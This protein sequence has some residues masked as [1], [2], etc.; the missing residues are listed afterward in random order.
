MWYRIYFLIIYVFS[1]NVSSNAQSK[2]PY[3]EIPSYP[4]NYTQGK[5]ISRMIDGLGYRFYWATENLRVL[6]L[7]F[8]PDTLARSTFETMEHIYGLSFMI[9]N[10]SK[11][12]VNERIN[13]DQMTA[14]ELRSAILDNLKL[15][16]EAMA[17]VEDLDELNIL[18]QGST[19][20]KALPFWH[21]LNGP[22]ADAIYHTGQIVSF[23]RASGNPMNP[24]VNVFIG[25]TDL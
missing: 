6:D 10:A 16:S 8:K 2:V 9:L 14:N 18:F 15:A 12:Q 24:K 17:L 22:L 4:A 7:N 21:V 11:N 13:P 25:K 20:R 23:R 1:L 5:V 19:G 3:K